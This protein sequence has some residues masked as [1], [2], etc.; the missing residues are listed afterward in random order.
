MIYSNSAMANVARL[1]DWMY[2]KG[3]E[4]YLDGHYGRAIA[5]YAGSGAIDGIEL[6]GL[7]IGLAFIGFSWYCK[8]VK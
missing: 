7:S 8:L 3:D 4:H 1:Q 2:E 5:L 6:L